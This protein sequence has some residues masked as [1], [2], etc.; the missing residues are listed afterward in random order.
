M[1]ESSHDSVCFIEN[2][3][4]GRQEV[5]FAISPSGDRIRYRNAGLLKDRHD[6]IQVQAIAAPVES[7][8]CSNA[9]V[10]DNNTRRDGLEFPF[11]GTPDSSASCV[12]RGNEPR[13]NHD[14]AHFWRES[15][16]KPYLITPDF[17]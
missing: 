11:V 8:I 15:P 9:A 10:I 1:I 6:R 7:E 5:Q 4:E 17:F 14:A 16:Y 3:I 12:S 13:Q 2:M